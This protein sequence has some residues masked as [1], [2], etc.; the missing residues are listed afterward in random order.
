[1]SERGPE[2]ANIVW[3][4]QGQPKSLHF[5]D[6]YF[7]KEDGIAE[8]RYVFL[9]GN[10]LKHRWQNLPPK[11][12]FTIGETGF[13]T[14][15]NFLL[16]WQLWQQTKA[17][18]TNRLHYISVERYPLSRQQL[19]QACQAW[20]ELSALSEQLISAYPP[21]PIE[22]VHRLIFNEVTLT[23][24]FDEASNAFEQLAAITEAGPNVS[25]SHVALGNQMQAIDAWFLDGFAPSKNPDMWSNKLFAAIAN[26]SKKDSSF[27]TFTAASQV[28]KALIAHEFSCEKIKGFGRKREMLIGTF[29][30]SEKTKSDEDETP[31][32][33]TDLPENFRAYKKQQI[34]AEP[35]WHLVEAPPSQPPK[36]CVV[37][38]G[39]IAGCHTAFALAQKG[40]RVTVLEQHERLASEAS[41]NHQG[42]VYAKL[43]L[44]PSPINIFNLHA[45]TFATNFYERHELFKD[46]GDACGVLQLAT[47]P[48]LQKQYQDFAARY[49]NEPTF[50]QWLDQNEIAKK[51]GLAS[52]HAGLFLSSSGWLSPPKLC[53]RLVEHPQITVRHNALVQTLHNKD[54]SWELSIRGQNRLSADT[55]IVANAASALAFHQSHY[56]PL[57][58]IRGQ[59]SYLPE[60]VQT[61]K[62]KSVIC[63]DGYAAPALDGRHSV[64]ATFTLHNTSAEIAETDH[65]ENI[66]KLRQLSPDFAHILETPADIKGKVGFRCTTPDYFPIVG[67]VADYPA[68]IERFGF[69]RKKANA[70]IDAPGAHHPGLYSLLGLGA[71]GLTYAPLAAE[72]LASLI[73][74]ETLP[75]TRHLYR[76]LHPSRFIIRDLMRNKR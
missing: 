58:K 21:Q 74:G 16:S 14:G 46:C 37:I 1:M 23:L 22:G 31:L 65:H 51:T 71:R 50:V 41:G 67:P 7:S 10:Q 27:A 35:S 13:G 60:E 47:Q 59:V 44:A 18:T 8:S 68:M 73:A 62:L 38:G 24:C 52:E 26:L 12:S 25:A 48:A 69:L 9:E 55:V 6:I 45:L 30:P 5:D 64:G 3:D 72:L 54:T 43:S 61:A 42:I 19:V 15:L 33:H 11:H 20:P 17:H 39:G 49:A 63:G 56:L 66:M 57:K 70:V 40:F 53:Q 32:S 36:H 76:Y 28:R 75:L 2:T 4:E 34:Q 29:S